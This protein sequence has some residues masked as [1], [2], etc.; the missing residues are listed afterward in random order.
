[1]STIARDVADVAY[2]L[3][4]EDLR[5]SGADDADDEEGPDV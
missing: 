5:E 2:G 1:M 3:C 4:E